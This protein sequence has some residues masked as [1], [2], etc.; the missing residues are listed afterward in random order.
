MAAPEAPPYRPNAEQLQLLAIYVRVLEEGFARRA[1]HV[2]QSYAK[3]T[4]FPFRLS[5]KKRF[6]AMRYLYRSF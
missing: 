5:K 6:W 3:G 2:Q 1:K 4:L